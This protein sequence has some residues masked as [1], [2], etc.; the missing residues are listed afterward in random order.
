MRAQC[1]S[2]AYGKKGTRSMC[3]P[4]LDMCMKAITMQA[5]SYPQVR[6]VATACLCGLSA[7]HRPHSSRQWLPLPTTPWATNRLQLPAFTPALCRSLNCLNGMLKD[8][9]SRLGNM[10]NRLFPM[11]CTRSAPGRLTR[12]RSPADMSQQCSI[13]ALTTIDVRCSRCAPVWA[14]R[15]AAAPIYLHRPGTHQAASPWIVLHLHAG[16]GCLLA[17]RKL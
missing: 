13:Q 11:S 12:L 15:C 3:S 16:S 4:A 10:P 6:Q 2:C 17:C 7:Y 8:S 1:W 9:R 5:C 14:G